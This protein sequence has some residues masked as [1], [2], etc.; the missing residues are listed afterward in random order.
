MFACPTGQ[1]REPLLSTTTTTNKRRPN[2]SLFVKG[3]DL[4]THRVFEFRMA[5]LEKVLAK[6]GAVEVAAESDTPLPQKAAEKQSRW[7]TYDELKTLKGISYGRIHLKRLEEK[8]K[9][10]ERIECG[11]RRYWWEHEIDEWKQRQ[12][13]ARQAQNRLN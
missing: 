9:F 10:P 3:F 2:L 1:K 4:M 8:G 7:L 6:C 13:D 5:T 12:A 11:A